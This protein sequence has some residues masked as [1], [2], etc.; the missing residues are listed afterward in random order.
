MRTT[1]EFLNALKAKNGGASDYR[2]SQLLGCT[3]ASVSKYRTGR[4]FFDNQTAIKMAKLLDVD[5]GYIAAC[6]HLERA[7]SDEEKELWSSIGALFPKDVADRL[8]I[9]LSRIRTNDR[10]KK[11]RF[12]PAL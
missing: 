12:C 8:C 11:P 6:V 1:I 3:R 5:A 7:K 4:S 9:M 10:R 2:I